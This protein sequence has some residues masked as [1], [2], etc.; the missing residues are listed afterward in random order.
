MKLIAAIVQD[1][2][3]EGLLDALMETGFRAT[4]IQTTGGFLR[5]SSNLILIGVQPEKV[6]LALEVIRGHCQSRT[7]LVQP[8]DAPYLASPLEVRV[9]GAIV[10]VW[11]LERYER[12]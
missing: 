9:G 12:L 10:F 7:Q 1:R 2:D 11:E 5:G 4:K 3:A 6:D 8:E